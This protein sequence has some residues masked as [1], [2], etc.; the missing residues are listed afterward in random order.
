MPKILNYQS[1][2]T[3]WSCMDIEFST[4]ALI[5]NCEM[6]GFEATVLRLCPRCEK[7]V[8]DWCWRDPYDDIC[9]SCIKT[10]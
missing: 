2:D 7:W 8:C 1:P 3:D 5:N 4:G 10:L 6:C 9:L